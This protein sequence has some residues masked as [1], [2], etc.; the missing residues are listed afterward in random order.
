MEGF[1]NPHEIM[2]DTGLGMVKMTLARIGLSPE[3][4]PRVFLHPSTHE[5][6][7]TLTHIAARPSVNESF[8]EICAD[9]ENAVLDSDLFEEFRASLDSELY[10]ANRKAAELAAEVAQL[11][12][13]KDWYDLE[14][15]MLSTAAEE[16]A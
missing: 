2:M 14:Q 8:A 4:I 9:I 10:Q 6:A 11:K 16:I 3:F 1:K 13:Y 5:V 15:S 12:K 7:I